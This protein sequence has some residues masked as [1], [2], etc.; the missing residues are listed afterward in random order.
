MPYVA[1]DLNKIQL[2]PPA[3]DLT[4]KEGK[5]KALLDIYSEEPAK[6]VAL[7]T[8]KYVP[9]DISNIQMDTPPTEQPKAI[10]KPSPLRG[11]LTDIIRNT[12]EIASDTIQ[13]TKQAMAEP[14]ANPNAPYG[15]QTID[16]TVRA[17]GKVG[18]EIGGIYGL[19]SAPVAG[20]LTASVENSGVLPYAAKMM[21]PELSKD[22]TPEQY[23][24]IA[25]GIGGDL[26]NAAF[27]GQAGVQGKRIADVKAGIPIKQPFNPITE[28]LQGAKGLADKYAA[29]YPEGS[30]PLDPLE[31]K[32][33]APTI[34]A[35]DLRS[36]ASTKFKEAD[37][38]GGTLNVAKN[39]AWIDNA[40]KLLPQSAEAKAIFGN[41]P[42]GEL[43]LNME[44]QR[45]KPMTLQ[46]AM[47]I[48]SRLGEMAM[49]NINPRT[50][51]PTAEGNRLFQ[52]QHSLRDTWENATESDITGGKAGFNAGKEGR[53]LWAASVR[54]NDVERILDRGS[55][56]DVPATAIKNGFKTYTS[57]PKNKKG[58]T[59]EE[60]KA[61]NHAAHTG[62]IGGAL[63]FAGSRLI[64]SVVG[65][66]GG[67]VGGGPLGAAAGATVGAMTGT[68]F[69]MAAGAL[70]KG[71]GEAVANL[72]SNRPAVQ[73]ALQPKLS[74]KISSGESLDNIKKITD[75]IPKKSIISVAEFSDSLQKK[76]GAEVSLQE[77]KDSLH[78]SAIKLPKDERGLGNG[79]KAMQDIIDYADNNGKRI[80]LTPSTDFGG[81]SVARLTEFYKRFGFVEN[82][83]RNK[84]F[85]TR[86]T[87]IREPKKK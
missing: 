62:V 72:I 79:S 19:I 87:M 23:H 52:L 27:M 84:D 60:W 7:S 13:A 83:G 48:D 18:N 80:T 43:I 50:G 36:Y 49:D 33:V 45:G 35:E 11:A 46:G 65:A 55:K 5:D 12:G 56:A 26:T 15:M 8:D 28:G 22:I 76:Y 67:A 20:A 64:S 78:L 73:K 34:P 41:T 81:S 10:E 86:E 71:R 17:L 77:N 82:K 68:P 74:D 59:D 63:K 70:Q 16:Q 4:T 58:W 32:T 61:L 25:R 40:D 37:A 29:K 1:V 31:M 42:V 39:N 44:N 6:P 47:E 69:R 57:N 75:I 3:Y 54:M 21:S 14:A 53:D 30:A 2:D 51:K 38:V 24:N 66:A 9:V 85:S